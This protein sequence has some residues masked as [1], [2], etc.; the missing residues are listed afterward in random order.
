MELKD[1]FYYGIGFGIALSVPIFFKYKNSII[2]NIFKTQARAEIYYN[3]LK[4]QIAYLPEENEKNNEKIFLMANK[5]IIISNTDYI[6]ENYKLMI[7]QKQTN[8][9]TNYYTYENYSNF[10]EKENTIY[11]FFAIELQINGEKYDIKLSSEKFN[12]Y[13]DGNL[14]LSKDFIT[15]YMKSFLKKKELISD[16]Y[17]IN[18]IDDK[19]MPIQ[20]ESSQK[21]QLYKNYYNIIN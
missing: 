21:I 1:C 13:I 18:I 11:K 10:E 12:F 19:F 4:S 2:Y 3:Y 6:P 16:D 14:I 8:G 7:Y 17:R 9:F 15:W 20:L 5:E